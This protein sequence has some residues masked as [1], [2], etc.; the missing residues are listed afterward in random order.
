MSGK[1]K[2]FWQSSIIDWDVVWN[3]SKQSSSNS[4]VERISISPVNRA[5]IY[6]DHT[7]N[8]EYIFGLKILNIISSNADLSISPYIALNARVNDCFARCKE[9]LKIRDRVNPCIEGRCRQ[10][11]IFNIAL[12]SVLTSYFSLSVRI[13]FDSIIAIHQALLWFSVRDDLFDHDT[14]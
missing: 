1:L 5:S 2:L 9:H 7:V 8:K 3:I 13:I 4:K 6:I 11:Y 14:I 12:K 10:K